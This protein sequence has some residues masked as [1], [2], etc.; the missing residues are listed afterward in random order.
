MG[1]LQNFHLVIRYKKG[2]FIKV[3]D[4]I[5][6]PIISASNFL[7][8]YSIVHENYIEQ[9]ASDVDFKD[10]YASFN[11]GN[12]VEE[13]DYHMHKICSFIWESYVYHKERDLVS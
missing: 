12:Q 8:N 9:Y 2:I 6:R 7:K 11:E 5:S 1:F 13:N 4:M 3:S 10:V